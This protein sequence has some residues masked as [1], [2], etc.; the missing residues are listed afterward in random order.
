[1]TDNDTRIFTVMFVCT[2]NTCRSPMAEGILKKMAADEGLEYM[3]VISAGIGTYDGYPVSE[4]SVIAAARDNVDIASLHSTQLVGDLMHEADL[5]IGLALNH[6]EKMIS[7]YPEDAHKVFMLRAFPNS[8][9]SESLSVADPIGM[10]LS[11]Y[12]KTYFEIKA[13]LER[14]WPHIKDR[15]K[16]K[17]EGTN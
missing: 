13:E 7:L 2:G 6:Y 8:D 16:K 11:E 5:I 1:M 14:I 4:N 17:I 9:A 10:D 12:Q 3:N 15:Y